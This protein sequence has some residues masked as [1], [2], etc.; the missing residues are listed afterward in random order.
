VTDYIFVWDIVLD[1]DVVIAPR[2]VDFFLCGGKGLRQQVRFP[3]KGAGML[4]PPQ[5][6]NLAPFGIEVEP[7]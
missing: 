4:F 6:G 7:V 5:P 3:R 1:V 2:H